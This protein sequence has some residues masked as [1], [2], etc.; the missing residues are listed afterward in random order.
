MN[1]STELVQ[2]ELLPRRDRRAAP[3]PLTLFGTS[4]PRSRWSGWP[5]SRPCSST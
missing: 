2:G 3:A 5:T 1:T 4:D